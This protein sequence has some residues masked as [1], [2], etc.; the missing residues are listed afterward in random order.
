MDGVKI[1]LFLA[2]FRKQKG[3]AMKSEDLEKIYISEI[4][5]VSLPWV[6]A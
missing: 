6:A 1:P 3:L 5:T 2:M 4:K